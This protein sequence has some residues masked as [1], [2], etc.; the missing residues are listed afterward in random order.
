MIRPITG[1]FGSCGWRYG[2]L[3]PFPIWS[4]R[5][6]EPT[7]G[8]WEARMYQRIELTVRRHTIVLTSMDGGWTATVD[9][10]HIDHRYGSSADAWTAA[11]RESERFDGL[12][13]D[14]RVTHS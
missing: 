7:L 4:R 5:A 3:A 2:P 8:A 11:V 10:I 14:A 13:A 6:D 1:T 9:G 12:A